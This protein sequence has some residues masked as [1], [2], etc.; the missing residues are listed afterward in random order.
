MN[1]IVNNA[2]RYKST[3]SLLTLALRVVRRL[4]VDLVAVVVAV[5]DLFIVPDVVV[6]VA[7]PR[8]K[9][10]ST[11]CSQLYEIDVAKPT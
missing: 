1:I 4:L 9:D 3:A 5:V 8:N 2:K 7:D 11:L 10:G 6:V